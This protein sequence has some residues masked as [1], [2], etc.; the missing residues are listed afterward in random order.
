MEDLTD[1]KRTKVLWR[2]GGSQ[3]RRMVLV[4]LDVCN[5]DLPP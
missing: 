5:D 4:L 2:P 3:K 1:L